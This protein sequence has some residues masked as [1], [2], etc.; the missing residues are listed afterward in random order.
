LYPLSLDKS[1]GAKS[2]GLGNVLSCCID[3]LSFLPPS[4][5]YIKKINR[6][7]FDTGEVQFDTMK[8]LQVFEIIEFG[9]AF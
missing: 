1:N 4:I 2:I 3:A 7:H 8:I 6:W 5:I 9:G